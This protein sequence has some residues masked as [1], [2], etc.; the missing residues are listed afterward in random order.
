MQ[1]QSL[2]LLVQVQEIEEKEQVAL[3]ELLLKNSTER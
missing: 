2:K 1:K 3:E